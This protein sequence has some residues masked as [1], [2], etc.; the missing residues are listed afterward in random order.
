MRNPNQIPDKIQ[1]NYHDRDLST[2]TSTLRVM[3]TRKPRI[4]H[5]SMFL[6]AYSVVN[7]KI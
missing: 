6:N 1:R 5:W 2:L 7:S 4:V 3:L